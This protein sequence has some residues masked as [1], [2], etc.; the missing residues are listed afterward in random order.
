[1]RRGDLA[2][3]QRSPDFMTFELDLDIDDNLD[4]SCKAHLIVFAA[5][6][7]EADQCMVSNGYHI[8]R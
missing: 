4:A 8:T 2:K 1:M 5:D 6:G 7:N 3:L